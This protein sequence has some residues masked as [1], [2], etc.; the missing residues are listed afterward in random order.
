MLLLHRILGTLLLGTLL[1][2]T[3]DRDERCLSQST[4]Q[5]ILLAGVVTIALGIVALVGSFVTTQL[6]GLG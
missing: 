2:G 1:P 6:A 4:E 5:A 3:R